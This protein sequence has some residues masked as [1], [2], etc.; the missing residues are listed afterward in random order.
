MS[1]TWENKD[2]MFG[3]GTL[4]VP[5][6]RTGTQVVPVVRTGTQVVPVVRTGTQVVPYRKFVP[7]PVP[8]QVVQVVSTGTVPRNHVS[9]PL[10]YTF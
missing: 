7:V 5:V 3:T 6:V 1:K 4:V 10:C 2:K 8:T 9:D